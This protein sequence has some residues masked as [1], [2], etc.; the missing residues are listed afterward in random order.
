MSAYSKTTSRLTTHYGPA[1]ALCLGFAATVSGCGDDGVDGA[2]GAGT[3]DATEISGRPMNQYYVPPELSPS[4]ASNVLDFCTNAPAG[5]MD[6]SQ[7]AWLSFFTS[8]EYGHYAY[9]GTML[10]DFGFVDPEGAT[11]DWGQCSVDQLAIESLQDSHGMELR[12]K[13]LEGTL[14]DYLLGAYADEGRWGS[15]ALR[16]FESY[17]GSEMPATSFRAWLLNNP[18]PYNAIEFISAS[19]S[20]AAPGDS[21]A[22]STQV[23]V[24]RHP[25]KNVVIAVF[26]GTEPA[27]NDVVVDAGLVK[28][29]LETPEM[30]AA[31]WGAGWG[32]VHGG[33]F[34]AYRTVDQEA[35]Q[36][37]DALLNDDVRPQIYLAGHSL[38]A[39]LTTVLASRILQKMEDQVA[40]GETPFDL[41]AVYTYGSPRVGNAQFASRF[42]ELAEKHGVTLARFRNGDDLVTNVPKIEFVHVGRMFHLSEDQ[43]GSPEADSA[44]WLYP[45]RDDEPTWAPMLADH[46]PSGYRI[47]YPAP[48]YSPVHSAENSGYYRRLNELYVRSRTDPQA[49]IGSY[50][51]CAD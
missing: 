45:S 6:L 18:K 15:C 9:L 37:G 21:T 17:D 24:A 8:N 25:G 40:A 49:P 51:H 48:S 19:D 42:E 26:R 20:D 5:E 44:M 39:A 43:P 22:G 32:K 12:D 1:M 33:F 4:G 28:V 23:M 13:M 16:W 47:D 34:N 35:Q 41:R 3:Q 11:L 10:R 50:D 2:V 7:A 27:W 36:I 29:D 30:A 31:G 38:G 14:Y 46:F